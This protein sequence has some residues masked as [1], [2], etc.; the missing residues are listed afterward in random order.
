MSIGGNWIVAFIYFTVLTVVDILYNIFDKKISLY[1]PVKTFIGSIWIITILVI[2]MVV[3]FYIKF[4][5]LQIHFINNHIFLP[6][7]AITGAST[8]SVLIYFIGYLFAI[9]ASNRII[10]WILNDLKYKRPGKIFVVNFSSDIDQ[11]LKKAGR[12]IGGLERIL[13]ITFVIL[14]NYSSIGFIFAAKTVARFETVRHQ[15]EYYI[16]GTLT[17]FLIAL[18]ISGIINLLS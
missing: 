13:V 17:S 11:S 8:Q 3:S 1:V 18:G 14:G 4:S 5:P 6:I 12:Y 2:T 16:V 7:K 9:H 10:S 15:A